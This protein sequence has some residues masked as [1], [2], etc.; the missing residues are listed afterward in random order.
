MEST[1]LRKTGTTP[2]R[3]LCPAGPAASAATPAGRSGTAAN[4]PVLLMNRRRGGALNASKDLRV[5]LTLAVWAALDLCAGTALAQT[6]APAAPAASAAEAAT[7]P[8][9]RVKSAAEKETATSAVPG[10][11]ARRSATATKTDTPLIETPQS[12][13]VVTRD[14]MDAIGATTLVDALGYTPGVIAGTYGQDSRYD[15]VT[16]RGFDA[17]SPGYYLDG[18][19]ARNN[20]NYATWRLDSYGAERIEVLRGPA[21]VLYGQNGPGGLVNVVSKRPTAEPMREFEFQFGSYSRRQI[22]ADVSGPLDAEG[23]LLYRITGLVRDSGT[24]VDYVGDDRVFIAPALTWHPSADTTLALLS[25][26]QRDRSATTL[27]FLPPEGTLTANPNGRIPVSFFVGEPDFDRFDKDQWALGYALEHRFGPTWTVRQNARYGRIDLDYQ[28]LFASGFVALNAADPAD[29]ANFRLLNRSSFGSREKVSALTLDNQAQANLRLGDWQHTLLLGLDFQRNRFDQVTFFGSTS[30][31]DAFAPVYG[32][33]VVVPA[34]YADADITLAQ[35]G[36]Y[37]QDQAKL[38]ERWVLSAGGRYDRATTSTD[39][40][41]T[42]STTKQTDSRF[43]GRAGVVYLAPSG[44]APYLS[45]SESFSPITTID[46]DTG[47]PFAPETGRQYEAG[48]RWQPSGSRDSYSAAIFDLRRRNYVTFDA[49]FTPKQTG[50]VLVRGL[51]LEAALEPMPGMNFTAAWTWLPVAKVTASV[52]PADI[53]KQQ[54]STPEHAVAL[55]ADH[56]WGQGVLAG[57]RLGVGLRYSGST[58]G[59]GEA[60]PAKLPART[61]VDVLIGYELERLRFALN[62]RNAA[63]KTYLADCGAT[64]CYFGSARSVVGTLSYRY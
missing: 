40:R 10:Y 58:S 42:S 45:Y 30:P 34:P 46:P 56:R 53:G 7:L 20:G 8:E 23:K 28:Q 55:W 35:T 14:R 31:L 52:A 38:G 15:W 33:P 6:V 11:T 54:A 47:R 4:A 61:L 22:A 21:S 26:F 12:I 17:Y 57:L 50:E 16:L 24:Q 36:L 62:L 29:P 49:S 63:D 48:V 43:T 51:E 9:V 13:S 2:L 5:G 41:L 59:Y 39:D 1:L 18:L 19:H 64:T 3:T 25:H 27:G 60:S 44:L 32:Q 37:V